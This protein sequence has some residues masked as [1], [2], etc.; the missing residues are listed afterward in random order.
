MDENEVMNLVDSLYNMISEAWGVPLGNDKCIIERERAL[1]ILDEIK[2][3][4]PVELAEAKRLVSARDEFISNAKREA[5]SVRKLAEEKAKTL[6]Q[7][8]EIYRVAQ[9]QSSE[10]IA[11]AQA[12]SD[13]L[14]RAASQY[15]EEIL[16]NTEASVRNTADQLRKQCEQFQA[17][18]GNETE[19]KPAAA[20]APEVEEA[21][22]EYEDDIEFIEEDFEK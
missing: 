18:F 9:Q 22:V 21:P 13:Q 14:R 4:M 2:G 11:N 15:A 12:K 20:P 17:Q 7:S 19:T 16:K 6:V 3:N 1:E 5:E 10:M 8:Q